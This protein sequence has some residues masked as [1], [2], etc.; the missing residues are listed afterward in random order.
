MSDDDDLAS[1]LPEAPPRPDRREAAI[2]E[3]LRRFDGGAALPPAKRPIRWLLPSWPKLGRA[4][5]G[6]IMSMALVA[7]IGVPIALVAL[8]E[9]RSQQLSRDVPARAE[10]RPF[11]PGPS[12]PD[13][14]AP[15]AKVAPESMLAQAQPLRAPPPPA[16]DAARSGG[17]ADSVAQESDR[18]ARAEPAASPAQMPRSAATAPAAPPAP[19]ASPPAPSAEQ[20]GAL[21]LTGSRIARRDFYGELAH[22][23][24]QGRAKRGPGQRGD[25]GHGLADHVAR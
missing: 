2:A 1:L 3:A 13:A 23:A 24:R 17:A 14:G 25:R 20:S 10:P 5:M 12:V 6:A 15:K 22:R 16:P 21:V 4:Q 11:A 19:A 18:F 8:R 9:E 7:V